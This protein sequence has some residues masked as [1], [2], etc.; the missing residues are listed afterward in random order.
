MTT[1]AKK[2]ADNKYRKENVKQITMRFFP[3]EEDQA[4]YDWIKS[5]DNMNE[6]LKSLVLAD[7]DGFDH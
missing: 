1:E 7:M 5:K 3:S 6:Y 4:I 2:K